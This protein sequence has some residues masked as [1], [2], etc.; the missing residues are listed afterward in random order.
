MESKGAINR[1]GQTGNAFLFEACITRE[2]AQRALI[3]DLI[4]ILG[5]D[6]QP[7]MAHLVNSGRLSL[8][9]VKEAEKILQKKKK[10][11]K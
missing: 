3:E 11:A 10:G 2:N 9:D 5:G 8:E 7:V 1:V 4:T 6:S